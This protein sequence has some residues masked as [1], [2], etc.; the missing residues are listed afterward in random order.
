[1]MQVR[2]AFEEPEPGVT[3]VKLRQTDVPEEDRQICFASLRFVLTSFSFFFNLRL[4]YIYYLLMQIRKFDCCGKYREGMAG[5]NF[6]QDTRSFWFW[7][8]SLLLPI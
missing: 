8:M 3:I 5:S 4:M 7:H 2:L 6:P 1:M